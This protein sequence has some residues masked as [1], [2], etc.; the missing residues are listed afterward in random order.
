M[1]NKG[2]YSA[3]LTFDVVKDFTFYT[4]YGTSFTQPTLNQLYDPI[5]GNKNLTPENADT[6]EAGFRGRQF[7]GQLTENITFWH[8]YVDNVITFD[9]SIPNP[10]IVNGYPFGAYGNA[11]AERSQG[12]EFEMA[13]QITPHLT[14][15]GNYT[16]TDAYVTDTTGAW[17]FMIENAR[18]MGNLGLT[19]TQAQFNVGTNVYMTDHR[20]RWA[21]DFYAPGYT[22]VDL[23]GR[24][25]LTDHFDLYAR[26]QNALD[27]NIVETLGYRNPGVYFVAG[28]SCRID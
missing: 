7:D 23:F 14:L 1:A 4:N 12:V 26:V 17:N 28:A 20:L 16:R 19:W 10:R 2:T 13:Y 15:N 9:Y 18:N 8:S 21:G 27:H 22:R 5:Y 11:E 25:H 3:G 24:Y 6:I